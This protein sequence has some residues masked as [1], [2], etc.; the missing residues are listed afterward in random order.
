MRWRRS[1][2]INLALQGGGAHGAFT[3]G[4][5]DRLLEHGGIRVKAISAT[6]SGAMNAVMLAYGLSRKGPER[7]REMLAQFWEQ[8][9]RRDLAMAPFEHPAERDRSR[10]ECTC[11]PPLAFHCCSK[12]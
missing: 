8:V 12:C 10:Y 9:V 2:A 11:C 3:W 6:S 7:A 1:K 4:V 5:L